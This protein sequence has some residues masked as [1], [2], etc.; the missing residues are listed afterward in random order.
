MPRIVT[1]RLPGR[2]RLRRWAAWDENDFGERGP[3]RVAFTEY[4]AWT[5]VV[6]DQA[7]RHY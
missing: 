3:I 4:A 6:D 7:A 1:L 2:W 5:K